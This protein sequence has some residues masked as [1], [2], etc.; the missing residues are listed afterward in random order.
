[1][2]AKIIGITLFVLMACGTIHELAWAEGKCAD[3]GNTPE[4]CALLGAES[5]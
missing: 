2:K 3:L 1:M 4:Q 5:L